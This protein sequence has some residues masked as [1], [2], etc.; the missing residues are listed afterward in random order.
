MWHATLST[1]AL[2]LN[3]TH[4]ELISKIIFYLYR[5][6]STVYRFF[7]GTN[8]SVT[9]FTHGRSSD[10]KWTF[11]FNFKHST[12]RYSVK[13]IFSFTKNADTFVFITYIY[14]IHFGTVTARIESWDKAFILKKCLIY[15][16]ILVDGME[17]IIEERK[18]EGF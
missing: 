5:I 1:D 13:V 11:I 7:Y 17:A 4:S 12:T 3:T 15:R 10:K 18:S 2:N 8:I 6:F 9:E 14:I 16:R